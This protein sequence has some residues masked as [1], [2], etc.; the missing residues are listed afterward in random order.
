MERLTFEPRKNWKEI[1]DEVGF[2]FCSIPSEDGTPYW[3]EGVGY[4]LTTAEVDLLDDAVNELHQM[5]LVAVG[6]IVGSGDYPEGYRLSDLAKRLIEASW[7]AKE[8]HLYGRFDLAFNGKAVKMLEYNADTPTALL[9]AAVAQWRWKEDLNLPD[10]FNSIH[11]KL[12]ER[13]KVIDKSLPAMTQRLYFTATGEREDF[14]T[15]EYLMDTAV[16][17]GIAISE[18]QIE[19]IGWDNR[20][21][22]A[23]DTLG[24]PITVCFKLYPWEWLLA[25]TAG[26][27]MAQHVR[28]IEPPWKMLLSS[29]ALLPVLWER[30]K[31]HPLLLPAFFDDSGATRPGQWARKPVLGR[32]GSNISIIASSLHAHDHA[33]EKPVFETVIPYEPPPINPAYDNSGY[34]LQQ[35]VDLPRFGEMHALIGAWVIGDESAGIGIR[36][37][38][39]I[40]TGNNSHFV[41]HYFDN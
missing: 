24:R 13:W 38:S 12:I 7:R 39:S 16:Q 25:D 28:F 23:V 9:E 30:H 37:D 4:H 32:E 26:P 8:P 22:G 27:D 5:C 17:A 2:D 35:W 20:H 34:V 6:T 14:G 31:D 41:P 15:L 11:E 19:H 18:I 36:E 33:G 1:S 40:I 29:K 21:H 3:S 10:Q